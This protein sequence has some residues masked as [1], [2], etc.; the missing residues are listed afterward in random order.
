MS[1]ETDALSQAL[2]S[3]A[4]HLVHEE[5]MEATLERVARLACRTIGDCD[6]AGITLVE[7]GRL[8]TAACTDEAALSVDTAQHDSGEGP[9]LEAFREGRVVRSERL[10]EDSRWPAFTGAALA[11]GIRSSLSL[12]LVVGGECLGVLNL[13]S[14]NDKGYSCDDAE[15]GL[16]F[17]TQASVALANAKVYWSARALSEQ[18]QEALASRDVIGQAKGIIMAQSGCDEDRAFDVLRRASQRENKKLRDVAQGVVASVRQRNL[19]D[20]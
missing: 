2:E 9:S 16:L 17:A 15:T 20:R 10:G 4:R 1:D 6:L 18:L 11:H 13:Y 14:R 12:P 5:G 19:A 3:L 8:I 7:D